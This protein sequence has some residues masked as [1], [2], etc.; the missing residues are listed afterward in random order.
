[1]EN[2]GLS[3]A[4]YSAELMS[5]EH[6]YLDWLQTSGIPNSRRSSSLQLRWFAG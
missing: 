1:M 5:A 2:I 6:V 3:F 4:G